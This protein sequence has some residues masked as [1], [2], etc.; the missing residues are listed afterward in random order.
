MT[1]SID[2]DYLTDTIEQDYSRETIS[3]ESL[4]RLTQSMTVAGDSEKILSL[5]AL[6]I[7][8]KLALTDLRFVVVNQEYGFENDVQIFSAR[9][10]DKRE[11]DLETKT[12]L[13]GIS[14]SNSDGYLF[15]DQ[16]YLIFSFSLSTNESAFLISNLSKRINRGLTD[17]RTDELRYIE[18]V[19]S[20]TISAVAS[21]QVRNDLVLESEKA[22]QHNLLLSNLFN[23]NRDF[24]TLFEEE[25]IIRVFSYYLMGHL[26]VTQFAMISDMLDT[27]VVI[28]NRFKGVSDADLLVKY[29]ESSFSGVTRNQD[30]ASPINT[31]VPVEVQGRKQGLVFLGEKLGGMAYGK[32][33]LEYLNSL[34][35]TAYTSLENANLFE[36][37]IKLKVLEGEL[38][39]AKSIQAG[40]FPE[41][42]PKI[43]G[44]QIAARNRSAKH[45]GGDYYDVVEDKNGHYTIVMADVSGKGVPASLI[46]ANL[47]AAVRLLVN[48]GFRLETV[49]EEL[50]TLICANTSSDKFVTL[51]L[52]LLKAEKSL[53]KNCTAGH[54]PPIYLRSDPSGFFST[55]NYQLLEKGG[56]VLGVVEGYKDY[57]AEYTEL[58]EGGA[59]IYY[60]DGFTDGDLGNKSGFEVFLDVVVECLN[61]SINNRINALNQ[62]SSPDL[63][64]AIDRIIEKM[65]VVEGIL[66]DDMT[67]LLLYKNKSR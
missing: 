32:Y 58:A 49:V 63:E 37:K 8:G 36:E 55:E 2:K 29:S 41:T 44:Y 64:M 48:M 3:F 56:M 6:S 12:I 50:N 4:S 42:L 27:P 46:M 1:D 23:I 54:P 22:A 53:L 5:A 62:S 17:L 7:M 65:S 14:G 39:L 45:V 11:L 38:E 9:G 34:V 26:K 30:E 43:K 31:F 57:E 35:I 67:L 59:V 10:L 60:T 61:E 20:I 24:A 52:S 15:F 21:L 19:I 66:P 40:L 28:V 47:Q 18:L 13:I 33:D 25:K 51:C 16:G